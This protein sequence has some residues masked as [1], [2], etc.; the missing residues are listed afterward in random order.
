MDPR[1]PL[2]TVDLA[3][4]VA[5][6]R[7]GPARLGGVRLVSVDG[8]A[9]SGKTTLAG[10]LAS[11]FGEDAALVHVDDLYAGWTLT[12]A[13]ARLQAGVLRPL[14]EGRPG[15]FH[16]FDWS[17]RWF[18]PEATVVPVPRV[19]LIEGCGSS[20]RALDA[21]T[22]LRIWVEA[23]ADLRLARGLARDGVHLTPE[24]RRWQG[25]EA[26]EFAREGTRA[27]ADLHV[28]GRSVGAGTGVALLP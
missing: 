27:R 4:V 12:G 5:R 3:D 18:R 24:W 7:T 11:A 26:A 9:G 6:V 1:P 16:A 17:T 28:D 25:T 23:P 14:A 19:L 20:P 2:R 21:W 15:A 13:V 8:P 22:T 10:R